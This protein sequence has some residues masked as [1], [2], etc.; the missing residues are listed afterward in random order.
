M[1]ELFEL[2]Y[3][4]WL[5]ADQKMDHYIS[6]ERAHSKFKSIESNMWNWT[7]RLREQIQRAKP[8]SL[9]KC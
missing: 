4:I 9:I 2:M 5:N 7:K 3:I 8:H 1:Y 6:D